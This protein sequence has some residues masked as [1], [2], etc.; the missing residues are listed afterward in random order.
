MA[1][2]GG[3]KPRKNVGPEGPLGLVSR[4]IIWAWPVRAE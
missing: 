3:Q 2:L 1:F 4:A